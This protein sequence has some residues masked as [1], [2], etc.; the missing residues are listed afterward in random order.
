M[1]ESKQKRWNRTKKRIKILIL[2]AKIIFVLTEWKMGQINSHIQFEYMVLYG[3]EWIG[4]TYNYNS[5][6]YTWHGILS[7]PCD[8]SI[9]FYIIRMKSRVKLYRWKVLLF[10]GIMC[11]LLTTFNTCL[12]AWRLNSTQ[13]STWFIVCRDLWFNGSLCFN[14]LWFFCMLDECFMGYSSA[15]TFR[16]W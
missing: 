16:V 1:Y 5:F 8:A 15:Q 9:I 11:Q 7:Y 14:I 13:Y 12:L 3:T 10:G 2:K 4:A 6:T